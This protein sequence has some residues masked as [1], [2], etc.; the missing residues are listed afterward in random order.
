MNALTLRKLLL[1]FLLLTFFA[2]SARAQETPRRRI[3][4]E[5]GLSLEVPAQ[6]SVQP[7]ETRK[8]LDATREALTEKAEI[9]KPRGKKEELLVANSTPAPAGAMIRLNASSPVRF[10]QADFAATGPEGLNALRSEL[11]VTFKK[12][13][14]AGGPKVRDVQIPRIERI[15]DHLAVCIVYLRDGAPGMPAWEVTQ[16][17]IPVAGRLIELTVSH[18]QTEAAE[19]KPVLEQVKRSLRFRSER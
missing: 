18:R 16:Y 19:W 17:K 3:A 9:E 5:H 15:N 14:A 10:T 12:L 8:E 11:L 7:P 13:E 6:W 4:L 1:L 2:S